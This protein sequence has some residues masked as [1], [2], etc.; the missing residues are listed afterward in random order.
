MAPSSTL[1]VVKLS[2]VDRRRPPRVS[3]AITRPS[4]MA[5][6]TAARKA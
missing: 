4:G 6:A 5:T 1:V 3:T 2:A